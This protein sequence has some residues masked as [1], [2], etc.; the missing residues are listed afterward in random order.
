MENTKAHKLLH[1]L[2]FASTTIWQGCANS[3]AATQADAGPDAETL[4]LDAANDQ[5]TIR[6]DADPLDAE[7]VF[8]DAL[9]D[10]A[11]DARFCEEGWP[12]TKGRLWLE[13]DGRTFGCSWQALEDASQERPNLDFCCE[14]P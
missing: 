3:H 6:V 7:N 4:A 2:V 13:I 1:G 9:S 11:S 10:P 5:R 12:T 8:A 14:V